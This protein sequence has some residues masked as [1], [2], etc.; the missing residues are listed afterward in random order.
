MLNK[1]WS[2]GEAFSTCITLIGFLTSV[3][4][5][6][7]NKASI[8]SETSLT[9]I[10]FIRHGSL[11]IFPLAFHPPLTLPGLSTVRILN[12]FIAVDPLMSQEMWIAP[13]GFAAHI[14]LVWL[15]PSVD[16][17]MFKEAA[18]LAKGFPTVITLVG[19]LPGVSSLVFDKVW[20]VTE[21]LATF[22]TLIRFLSS[23]DSLMNDEGRAPDEGLATLLAFIGFLPSVDS[24][25]LSQAWTLSKSLSTFMTVMPPIPCSTFLL[26]L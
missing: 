18:A 13:K 21:D 12:V 20:T 19:L 26:S 5:L 1:V 22:L 3:D 7:L 15:L 11:N 23:V 9:L 17:V 25:V 16:F 8:P 6:M 2:S 4:F 24:P 10:T 14:A